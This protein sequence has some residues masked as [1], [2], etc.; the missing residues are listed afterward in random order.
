MFTIWMVPVPQ[1][2]IRKV[3]LEKSLNVLL[4]RQYYKTTPNLECKIIGSLSIIKADN[5]SCLHYKTGTEYRAS[6]GNAYRDQ[7]GNAFAGSFGTVRQKL[8]NFD[9]SKAFA[10]C[11][12]K[13]L[14]IYST[15]QLMYLGDGGSIIP[16]IILQKNQYSIDVGPINTFKGF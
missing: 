9:A 3:N 7:G 13:K 8:G 14:T 6:L 10:S 1:D 12:N 5:Y 11:N 15:F 16:Y 2:L 4:S